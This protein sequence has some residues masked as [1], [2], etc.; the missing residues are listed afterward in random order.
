MKQ[1]NQTIKLSESNLKNLVKKALNEYRGRFDYGDYD[2]DDYYVRQNGK[3]WIQN[4]EN[5]KTK[6]NAPSVGDKRGKRSLERSKENS[7]V[8]NMFN[9]GKGNL[10]YQILQQLQETFQVICNGIEAKPNGKIN[11]TPEELKHISDIYNSILYLGR[12]T[13]QEGARTRGQLPQNENKLNSIIK[14]NIKKVLNEED[15]KNKTTQK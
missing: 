10:C 8:T 1:G 7:T 13:K 14:E 2:G 9:Y 12:L 15:K 5:G 11:W 3:P 6:F 4:K